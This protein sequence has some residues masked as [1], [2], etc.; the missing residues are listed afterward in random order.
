LDRV[1]VF[2]SYRHELELA[3]KRSHLERDVISV[4]PRT[5]TAQS[6][7]CK[8]GTDAIGL[9]PK[10]GSLLK[11]RELKPFIPKRIVARCRQW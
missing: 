9:I 8:L 4:E 11:A 6:V 3:I 1:Q 2:D 7:L 10:L 5:L